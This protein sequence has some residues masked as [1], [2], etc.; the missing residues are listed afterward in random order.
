VKCPASLERW[1][2]LAAQND[3][4]KFGACVLDQNKGNN[5]REEIANIVDSRWS[6]LTHFYMTYDEKES[7]KKEFGFSSVPFCIALDQHG[8]LVFSGQPTDYASIVQLV[9]S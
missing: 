3:T 1:G 5:N 7:A 2:E 4:V 6:S 9:S 8:N